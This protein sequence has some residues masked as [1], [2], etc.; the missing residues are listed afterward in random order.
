MTMDAVPDHTPASNP[1]SERRGRRFEREYKLR[2]AVEL[3]RAGLSWDVVAE[4]AGYASGNAALKA[5]TRYLERKR[6]A[7]DETAEHVRELELDRLDALLSSVWDRARNGH[8]D[9]LDAA[10]KVHDRRVKLDPRLAAA[11]RPDPTSRDAAEH[12]ARAD[13]ALAGTV[14]DI[15]LTLADRLSFTPE[16][17][18]LAPQVLLSELERRNLIPPGEHNAG[19]RVVVVGEVES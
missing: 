10:L 16:Q 9:A 6:V 8:T 13:G 19:E 18:V 2:R 5:V 11:I 17:R 4:G 1:T 3:A 15:M 14:L 12:A 7:M